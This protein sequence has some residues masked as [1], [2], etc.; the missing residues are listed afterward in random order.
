MF[1]GKCGTENDDGAVFCSSC[2][3]S[4]NEVVGNNEVTKVASYP[5]I[6]LSSKLFYPFFEICLWLDLILFT[7]A[8]GIVGHSL[9]TR[10]DNYTALG[11]IIGLIVGF[12]IVIILGGLV[13]IFLKMNENIGKLE[14]KGS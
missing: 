8:G 4:T 9:S 11:V 10:H 5:L 14:K 6:N 12:L 3:K 13:S 2:G 7:V 1:C